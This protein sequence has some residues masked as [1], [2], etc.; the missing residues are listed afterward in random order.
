MP[1]NVKANKGRKEI[2]MKKLI[3]NYK[4]RDDWERPVYESNGQVYVD[5]NPYLNCQSEVRIFGVK[6]EKHPKFTLTKRYGIYRYFKI[7]RA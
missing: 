6:N 2:M 3:L 5:V 1:E 7:F 4:G